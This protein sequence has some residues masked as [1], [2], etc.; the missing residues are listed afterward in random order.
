[1]F[2]ALLLSVVLLADEP[3]YVK[4]LSSTSPRYIEVLEANTHLLYP[5]IAILVVA[6]IAFGVIASWRTEDMDGIQKAEVKREVIRELRREMVGL[7][8]EQLTRATNMPPLK[9]ARILEDMQKAGIL[10][11]RTDTRRITTYRLKGLTN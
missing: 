11:S 9:L 1:V 7:T 5:A 2:P 8:V 3:T 4:P 10:E 6:L